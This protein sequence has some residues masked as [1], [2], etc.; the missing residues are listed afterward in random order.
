MDF[1]LPE[2]KEIY[3]FLIQYPV[4]AVLVGGMV[5][6]AGLTQIVKKTYLAYMPIA[7]SPVSVGRYKATVR[8]LSCLSTF[9]FSH[10]LWDTFLTHQPGDTALCA[11]DAVLSPL[12]YDGAR[13]LIG[14]KFPEFAKRWGADL[15]DD[16]PKP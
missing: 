3:A 8:V 16:P 7:S 15:N 14:W 4:L 6:G 1:H 2:I 11:G 9:L 13:A 10:W 5:F 12:V